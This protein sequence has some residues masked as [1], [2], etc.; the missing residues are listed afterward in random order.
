[1][2][3]NLW[4]VYSR[5]SVRQALC[6]LVSDWE[7]RPRQPY[8]YGAERPVEAIITLSC[9]RL[10]TKSH[11][12]LPLDS[13]RKVRLSVLASVNQVATVRRGCTAPAQKLLN[14]RLVT[15]SSCPQCEINY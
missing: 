1:M 8:V 5:T 2:G 9:S 3:K 13:S 12:G 6:A 7:G 4:D 15:E 14:T 11:E 10:L